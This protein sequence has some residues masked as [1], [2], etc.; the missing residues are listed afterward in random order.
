MA[1]IS[2]EQ[3]RRIKES[4][5]IVDIIGQYVDLSNSGKNMKGLCPFHREKT[6]S[7]MVSSESQRYHCFGCGEGGDVVS[8]VMKYNNIS[9][10]EA[11]KS[12]ADRAGIEIEEVKVDKEKEEK[13]K[14]LYKI[15]HDAMMY[16][17]KNF[18]T[19]RIPQNYLFNRELN[20]SIVNPFMLGYAKK[21]NNLLEYMKS[22][23]H[24][25]EDLIELGL[26]SK[27]KKE[28]Y[29]KFRN[30]LMFPIFDSRNRVIGF[31]GRILDDK[32]PKYLNSQESLIF[33]KGD[34][35]YGINTL[36]DRK[37]RDSVILVEG[38]MDVIGLYQRGIDNACASLGTA[39]TPNQGKLVKRQAQRVYIS[40]DSDEAG[41]K[42]AIR[43]I[44]I[45][46]NLDV[47]PRIVSLDKGMDPDDY[48]KT[49]G[50][51]AYLK[52]LE[53]SLHPNDFKIK[54]IRDKYDFTKPNQKLLYL[55]EITKFLSSI[56]M[57]VVRDEYMAKVSREDNIDIGS[58]KE[59][60]SRLVSSNYK[61]NTNFIY[62]PIEEENT[63]SK[64]YEIIDNESINLQIEYLKLSFLSFEAFQI[65]KDNISF[66]KDFKILEILNEIINIWVA[67]RKP[68]VKMLLEKFD[69]SKSISILNNLSIE[70]LSNEDGKE[71][72]LMA[73]ELNLRIKDTQLKIKR[74]E[75][76]KELDLIEDLSSKEAI[77]IMGDILKINAYINSN[78][79]NADE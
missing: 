71:V 50:K 30:R 79:G 59:D 26:V 47:T 37:N 52:K 48:V 33:H 46:E 6:P 65:L 70:E 29:D 27:G 20:S 21:G 39:L 2:E 77:R 72:K 17:Y 3:A 40:Y 49:Y 18:L 9:Y 11:L 44:D 57:S 61:D 42:A 4:N 56:D 74:D 1:F 63:T 62:E 54:V 75:L 51:D 64:E 68:T 35:I 22:L 7:F 58:L 73:E 14:R 23:G 28:L 41:L 24:K 69:D 55:D 76:R 10:P 31:G 66:V 5:D 43:A 60:V 19:E 25:E 8:F 13:K 36:K 34:N 38:Y 32:M 15:N 16:F 45:F 78:G 12:L 67:N 53:D